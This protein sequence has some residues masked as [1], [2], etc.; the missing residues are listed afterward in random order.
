MQRRDFIKT[1]GALVA[2]SLLSAPLTSY[3]KVQGEASMSEDL[4]NILFIFSD[5]Q[6]HDTYRKQNRLY[7][8]TPY[9]NRL[10]ETGVQFRQAFCR[11]T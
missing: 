3:Y 9:M 8:D 2:S 11:A 5:Q 10:A 1:G 6:R 7:A 4:P